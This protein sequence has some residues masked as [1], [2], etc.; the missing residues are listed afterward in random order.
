M[1]KR[2]ANF[3]TGNEKVLSFIHRLQILKLDPAKYRAYMK[4]K[5]KGSEGRK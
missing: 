2:I 3:I 1:F 4:K 5:S